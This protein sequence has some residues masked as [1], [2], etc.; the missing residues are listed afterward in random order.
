M[1]TRSEQ[2]ICLK[3]GISYKEVD[4]KI[5][6]LRKKYLSKLLIF[7]EEDNSEIKNFS[8]YAMNKFLNSIKNQKCQ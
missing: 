3:Y 1:G 4:K 2:E 7:Q 5:K 8:D 6:L